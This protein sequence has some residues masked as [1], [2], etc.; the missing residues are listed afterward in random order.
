MRYACEQG[1]HEV[2]IL[3]QCIRS[4]RPIPDKIA[5]APELEVGLEFYYFAFRDLGTCRSIGFSLGPIPWTA[6]NDYALSNR[7]FGNDKE[8]F[9]DLMMELDGLYLKWQGDIKH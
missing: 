8:S 6:M 7:L 5:N 4:R 9:I 3:E 1:P 2:K